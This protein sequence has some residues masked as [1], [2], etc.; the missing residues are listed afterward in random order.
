MRLQLLL[1]HC[2]CWSW[3]ACRIRVPVHVASMLAFSRMAYWHAS[4]CITARCL[5]HKAGRA[6][7]A[8]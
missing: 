5:L 7:A 1:C 6:K 4:S 2:C 3:C 8:Y